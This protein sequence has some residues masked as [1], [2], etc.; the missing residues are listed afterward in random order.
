MSMNVVIK[1]ARAPNGRL[2]FYQHWIPQG[3]RAL[4]IFV[5]D[6]GDH[7]G[8]YGHLASRFTQRG[9][10]FA[11]YDQR[12]HGQSQG[13]RGHVGRFTDLVSDLASFV[14]FS[15][16]ALA[17]GTMPLFIVGYGLGALVGLNYLLLNPSQVS[18][19]ISIS[20]SIKFLEERLGGRLGSFRGLAR[21]WPS[22]PLTTH[23]FDAENLVSDPQ[24]IANIAGDPLFHRR[25]TLGTINEIERILE[26]VMAMPHRINTPMLMLA[27]S[28][29]RICDPGGTV[30][31]STRLSTIDKRHHI[32]PGMYHDLLHDVGWE[33]VAGDIESWIEEHTPKARSSGHQLLLDRRDFLWE[34]VS[35]Q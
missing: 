11:L 17:D 21:L 13:P 10:A 24:E 31:F 6:L 30:H 7:V 19:F 12:G 22:L 14:L 3:A 1:F 32:Y 27:G 8:R 16:H 35:S 9:L 26:L 29:D 34:N 18:G 2:Y 5:H 15:R 20:A 33:R 4:V 28:D 23:S 25:I